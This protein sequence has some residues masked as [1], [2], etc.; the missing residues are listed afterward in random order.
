MLWATKAPQ[1]KEM[2]NS[3]SSLEHRQFVANAVD[4]MVTEKAV[5]MLPPSEKPW[6]VSPLGVV[7]KR[8]TNKFPLT[9]N[10]R[11]VNRHLGQKAFKLEELKDL[12]N[13]VER[14]DHAV[15]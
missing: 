4:D 10:M 5:T 11:Y 9:V 8:G 3:S 15:S 13:L 7:P 12:A 1:H 6:V 14:G 2:D